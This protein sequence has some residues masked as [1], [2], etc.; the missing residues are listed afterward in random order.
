MDKI[1]HGSHSGDPSAALLEVLDPEQNSSFLDHYM[2]V[3]IDLSNVLFVCTANNLDTIPGPLLDRMEVINLSG[4]VAEEKMQIAAHYLV[5][6]A[7]NASGLKSDNVELTPDAIA[8]LLKY[9]CRESGVRNLKKHIEKVFRKAAL[10]YVESS[11]QAK[12]AHVQIKITAPDLKPYVG[13]P[14]YPDKRL[15]KETP[16]GVIPGLAFNSIGKRWYFLVY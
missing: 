1:G 9:Y 10:N 8:H 13:N 2:D 12:D 14:V 4:Y 3:P 6:Q 15:W 11:Q 5:P 16:V 7:L